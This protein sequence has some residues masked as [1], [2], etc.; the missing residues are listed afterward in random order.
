MKEKL[1]EKLPPKARACCNCSLLF[2][3]GLFLLFHV[4]LPLLILLLFLSSLRSPPFF[5]PGG[6]V[7][8]EGRM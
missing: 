6:K 7:A 2:F 3:L 4:S 5:P 1:K 8:G